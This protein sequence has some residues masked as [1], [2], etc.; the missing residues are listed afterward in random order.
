MWGIANR[1]LEQF[2]GIAVARAASA[3]IDGPIPSSVAG[4][5]TALRAMALS[6]GIEQMIAAVGCIGSTPEA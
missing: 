2:D 5:R 3:A 6:G 1:V 4:V